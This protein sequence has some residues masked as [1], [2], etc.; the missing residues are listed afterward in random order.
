MAPFQLLSAATGHGG[1]GLNGDLGYED[2]PVTNS[3]DFRWTVS[4]HANSRLELVVHE[5]VEVRGFLNGSA[6]FFAGAR[7]KINGHLLGS[8]YQAHDVT[9][10]IEL[11]PGKYLLE[12]EGYGSNRY[13]HTVWGMDKPGAIKKLP[14][15][16]AAIGAICKDENHHIVDW[17]GHHLSIGVSHIYLLDNESRIPL[18]TTIAGAG[19]SGHVTVERFTSTAPNALTNAYLYLLRKYGPECR[20]MA[21]I[22]PDEYIVVKISPS[23]PR[24]LSA[25]EDYGALKVRWMMFG[26]NGHTDFQPDPMSSFTDCYEDPHF[27]SIVQPRFVTAVTSPHHVETMAGRPIVGEHFGHEESTMQIQLN[28]YWTRSSSDW[29]AK[30]ARGNLDNTSDRSLQ[31]F[32]DHQARCKY[33]DHAVKGV[34]QS[35]LPQETAQVNRRKLTGFIHLAAVN[36]WRAI[37]RSQMGKIVSSGLVEVCDGIKIGIVG[38]DEGILQELDFLPDKV[39]VLFCQ[40]GLQQFEFPTLAAL[41]DHCRLHGGDVW[42]IHS[43]GS[44]NVYNEQHAWRSRMEASILVQHE[45]MREKLAAGYDAAGG[46]GST[47]NRW[48]LVGNFWWARSEHVLSLPDIKQHVDWADRWN[49]EQWLGSNGHDGFYLHNYGDRLFASYRIV[50]SS[51]F[52]GRITTNGHH[53]WNL[54][55]VLVPKDWRYDQLISAHAPCT[56]DIKVRKPI[57]LYGI[58]SDTCDPNHGKWR[59]EYKVDGISLA[60]LDG[61]VRRTPELTLDPGLHHLEIGITQGEPWGAH[62]GWAV[63]ENTLAP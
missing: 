6:G 62:T 58:I 29:T 17:I 54:E 31:N 33:H 52:A 50:S 48:P 42:Y 20:W 59:A 9:D 14:V 19:L 7:F 3:P 41:Q 45:L 18:A 38:A 53:G 5:H 28:H 21:L 36:H 35:M 44:V 15:H 26:S 30:M 39:S 23:L 43:K 25:Y 32:H 37:L 49:A 55:R 1:I 57:T 24:F 34:K 60:K 46:F 61:S 27:K 12:I 11:P 47:E 16:Y 56:I 10:S 51:A 2:L 13:G 8:V 4:A 63:I 22:D 40:P